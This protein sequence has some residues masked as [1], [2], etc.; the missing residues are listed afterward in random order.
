M[1]IV[2]AIIVAATVIGTAIAGGVSSSKSTEEALAKEK[3]LTK[4]QEAE[5]KKKVGQE[6]LLAESRLRLGEKGLKHQKSMVDIEEADLQEKQKEIQSDIKVAGQQQLSSLFQPEE[7]QLQMK[8]NKI[9]RWG[10]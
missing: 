5:Y 2:A 7:D 9:G 4:K 1:S 6:N 10:I 8:Q 3:K